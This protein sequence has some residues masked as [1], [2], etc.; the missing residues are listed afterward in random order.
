MSLRWFVLLFWG[1]LQFACQGTSGEIGPEATSPDTSAVAQTAQEVEEG[2]PES[3]SQPVLS[4]TLRKGKQVY[5]RYCAVCHGAEGQGDGFNA[6]NLNPRPRDFTE[7][8]FLSALS[9]EWLLEVIRQGGRG[10]KRSVLMPS[11]E[12]TLSEAQMRD[13]VD[14]LRYLSQSGASRK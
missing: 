10:V 2:E 5:D 9:D 6:Y 3:P 13:V 7:P 8:G 12:N 4:Y 1:G 11:Y 14:Y